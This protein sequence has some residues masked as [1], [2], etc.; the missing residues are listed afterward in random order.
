MNEI[1][2][3]LIIVELASVLAG[4]AVGLFFAELGAKVI[5]IENKKTN[6]DVTRSWKLASEDKDSSTSAY[7]QSIN[8]NKESKFLDLADPQDYNEAIQYIKDADIVISNFK[9]GSAETLKLDFETLK[10][11]NNK[12]IYAE[13]S[14]YGESDPRPGFDV[15]MQAETGWIS[16]TGTNDNEIAKLPVALID[17]LTAH[18]LK[19]GI[20]IALLQ[21]EQLGRAQ[22]VSASLYDSSIAS[23]ANQ[24]SNYLNANQIPKRI[25][26]THPNIAPY[27]DI[28]YTKDGKAVILSVGTQEQFVGLTKSLNAIELSENKL[29]L[30]NKL[31]VFNRDT[32]VKELNN[33][34]AS[35]SFESITS[36]LKEHKV[37]FSPIKNLA[38]VFEDPN[39]QKLMY[40]NIEDGKEVKRVKS[41]VFKLS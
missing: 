18:Q 16:M 33:L 25:G 27:G 15:V 34:F 22:K 38:E 8:W 11:I 7:Y 3:D 4:P 23:L 17:L 6:G 9:Q 36:S 26:T 31:R 21:R 2:K 37:P 14:S 20:L 30:N 10:K 41:V 5:K 39:A 12:L 24:A 35:F 28:V 32:L 19:E 1:F 40:S 29:Y 13:V